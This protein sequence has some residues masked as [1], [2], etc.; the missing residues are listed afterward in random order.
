[1]KILKSFA[2]VVGGSES[3][4]VQLIAGIKG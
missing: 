2:P 3:S 4:Q 1:P